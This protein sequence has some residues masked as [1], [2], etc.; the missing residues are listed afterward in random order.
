MSPKHMKHK[1]K[2]KSD[3]PKLLLQY[4][5]WPLFSDSFSAF[6]HS[7]DNTFCFL[8]NQHFKITVYSLTLFSSCL[9]SLVVCD[10]GRLLCSWVTPGGSQRPICGT[11]DGTWD[12]CAHSKCL[13]CYTLSSP[14]PH[15]EGYDH[16]SFIYQKQASSLLFYC[17]F[18]CFIIFGTKVL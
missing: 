1:E 3:G 2:H 8:P 18:C 12:I 16:L 5:L 10:L 9:F 7:T 11:R 17:Y 15:L 14:L 4:F 6:L 13:T